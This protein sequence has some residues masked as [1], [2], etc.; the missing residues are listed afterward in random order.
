M[1]QMFYAKSFS[2]HKSQ[3]QNC[4]ITNKS[5]THWSFSSCSANP[6]TPKVACIHPGCP[7]RSFSQ[8]GSSSLFRLA[9]D[10][11][12]VCGRRPGSNAVVMC[13]FQRSNNFQQPIPKTAGEHVAFC[14]CFCAWSCH[15]LTQ[16]QPAVTG[17]RLRSGRSQSLLLLLVLQLLLFL[18]AE[19]IASCAQG[20]PVGQ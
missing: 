11:C 18:H 9:R 10:R 14:S 2:S 15:F 19:L 1:L 17:L 3:L 20:H 6:A 16:P 5:S 12:T 13:F 4:R 7:R 8:S